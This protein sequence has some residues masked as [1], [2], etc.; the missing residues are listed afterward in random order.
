MCNIT[1]LTCPSLLYGSIIGRFNNNKYVRTAIIKSHTI[2]GGP[3]KRK[4]GNKA[5]IINARE[6]YDGRYTGGGGGGVGTVIYNRR[7]V[8][9]YL[10]KDFILEINSP[11]M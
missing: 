10:A 9:L 7:C 3:K 6:R 4:N 8:K 5:A 2:S 11:S 1:T